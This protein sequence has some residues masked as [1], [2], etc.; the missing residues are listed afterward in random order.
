MPV[1]VLGA[2]LCPPGVEASLYAA[3]MSL[4]NLS[5]GAGGFLGG[6]L[7][8]GCGPSPPCSMFFA[9]F[10]YLAL[11][12]AFLRGPGGSFLTGSPHPLGPHPRAGSASRSRTSATSRC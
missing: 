6:L 12:S 8:K 5:G 10:R 11:S 7:T 9:I 4:N 1:L 2:N 3:L